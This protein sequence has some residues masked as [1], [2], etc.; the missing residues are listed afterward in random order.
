MKTNDMKD[1]ELVGKK[2]AKSI[3]AT[4]LNE[5][6]GFILEKRDKNNNI[7]LRIRLVH[8][9]VDELTDFSVERVLLSDKKPYIK[10]V[11]KDISG[12][13]MTIPEYKEGAITNVVSFL[14]TN[15]D[16]FSLINVDENMIVS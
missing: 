8:N 6:N 5:K 4:F 15:G 1:I 11:I 3:N 10:E 12:M 14:Y 7:Y 16:R 9:Y 13:C 2:I